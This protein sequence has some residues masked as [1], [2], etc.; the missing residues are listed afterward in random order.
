MIIDSHCHA[1]PRWPYQPP[2]PDGESRGRVEQLLNEMDL[3]GVDQAVV[4]CARIDHNPDNNDYIAEQVGRFPGRLHQFPDVDCAWTDTYHQPGAVDRLRDVADR[5]PIRGFTHYLRGDDDGAWLDGPEGRAFFGV[6]AE[7]GL[8]ASIA[9]RPE[10]QPALRRVAERYPTMPILCHHLAGLRVA[11]GALDEKLREVLASAAL[12]NICIKVSG[13]AY[14]SR[15]AWEYPYAD[16]AP[17]LRAL[18]EH[19]GPDRLCWGSDYPVVRSS[20]TYQQSLE[21]FRT[22]CTFIP[23]EDQ[24]RILGGTLGALLTGAQSGR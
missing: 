19:F 12:P 23:T 7:R 3:H 4:I 6:A 5:W 18:Y 22:H 9:G 2:V 17:I 8:I 16:T 11:D 20:M 13:F 10:H 21:A 24:E 15:V 1:W 14:C